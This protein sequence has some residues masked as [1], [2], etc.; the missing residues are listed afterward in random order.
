M[1]GFERE[2]DGDDE[3]CAKFSFNG[4][5]MEAVCQGNSRDIA[6][7]YIHNLFASDAI[8]ERAVNFVGSFLDRLLQSDK[9]VLSVID[10]ILLALDVDRCNPII[11]GECTSNVYYV[12]EY[13][14]IIS[15]SFDDTNDEIMVM[16]IFYE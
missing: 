10:K 16:I 11:K 8:Q 14:Y 3:I 2:R 5:L 7:G 13:S 9:E 6:V 15:I 1:P 12:S 4:Q